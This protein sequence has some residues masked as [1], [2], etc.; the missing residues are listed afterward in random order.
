[1]NL[2]LFI[3]FCFIPCAFRYFLFFFFLIFSSI[4]L[5]HYLG[6]FYFLFK[7][8]NPIDFIKFLFICPSESHLLVFRD[9]SLDYFPPYVFNIPFFNF[10]IHIKEP[11]WDIAIDDRLPLLCSEQQNWIA[12]LRVTQTSLIFV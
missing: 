8:F 10:F 6:Y 4:H 5:L 9:D 11:L 2:H 7:N 3:C 12:R 1:L